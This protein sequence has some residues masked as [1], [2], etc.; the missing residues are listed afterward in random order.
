MTQFFEKLFYNPRWYHYIVA[1]VLLPLSF[2]YGLVGFTKRVFAQPKSY[3][4]AIVSIGNIVVGGSGKTPFAIALIEYLERNGY[5]NIT[6][7]SRGFGRLSK[8]LIVVK[9]H[10]KIQ[11]AVAQS[12]D[13]AMLVAQSC[14]CNVIVSED[15]VKAIKL[16]KKRGSKIV[17]LDDA[18]SKVEID[19]F[20]ILLESPKLKNFLPLPA[21]PLRE[22]YSSRKKADLIVK[23]G[24]HFKRVVTFENLSRRMLLATAIANPS[25]LE[26]YLPNSVIDRYYLPDHSYFNK[27]ILAEKMKLVDAKTLLV[28]QKDFVKLK[29]FKLPV[30]IMKLKLEINPNTLKS[31]QKYIEERS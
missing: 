17:I 31:I 5:G 7:I 6:Y 28:T 9:E 16:A 18:F 20:D 22:F 21:G 8:G 26:Q 13:E 14:R 30:S 3:T 2:L 15:R 19:K 1:F 10:N 11:C 25:R 23:E 24:V 12:G 4:I 29:Q 27:D